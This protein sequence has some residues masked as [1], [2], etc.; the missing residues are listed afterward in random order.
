[1]NEWKKR[2][3]QEKK[4]KRE[5][6]EEREKQTK[7]KKQKGQ[8]QKGETNLPKITKGAFFWVYS[9]I[10]IVGISQTIVHSQA[11]LIPEWL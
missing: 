10:G 5:R 2:T 1:M 3:D 9:G 7:E 6:K 8:Q 4:E 11:T